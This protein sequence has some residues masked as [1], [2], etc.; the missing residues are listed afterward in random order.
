MPKSAGRVPLGGRWISRRGLR[1]L[2][3][4]SAAVEYDPATEALLVGA[5]GRLPEAPG[6]GQL[7]GGA[8]PET[9]NPGAGA[10]DEPEAPRK[11]HG[12]NYTSRLPPEA[13]PAR[14][15]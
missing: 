3:A 9:D 15:A 13:L 6:T 1:R 14:G 2:P 5:A 8:A 7:A 10:V 4:A 12:C 11:V